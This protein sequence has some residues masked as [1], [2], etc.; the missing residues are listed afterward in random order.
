MSLPPS[1]LMG[2]EGAARPS[3]PLHQGAF[4]ALLEDGAL[5]LGLSQLFGGLWAQPPVLLGSS[6]LPHSQS[7]AHPPSPTN[8]IPSALPSSAATISLCLCC[9]LLHHIHCQK[10][11]VPPSRWVP[12]PCHSSCGCHRDPPLFSASLKR[13][14]EAVAPL[15][16]SPVPWAG[17]GAQG[18]AGMGCHLLW[19]RSAQASAPPA[20][21]QPSWTL[22][23]DAEELLDLHIFNHLQSCWH[24]T[25]AQTPKNI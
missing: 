23:R 19:G 15:E 10:A 1:A 9:F 3:C 7:V 14:A 8:K 12:H 6:H 13:R 20:C 16:P 11:Q 22:P 18:T 4:P 17:A 2:K 21:L 24:D 25:Y 5:G